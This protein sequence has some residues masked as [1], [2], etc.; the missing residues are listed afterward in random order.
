M[1]FKVAG[2]HGGK[3]YGLP[4]TGRRV[5]VPEIG[6]MRFTDGKWKDAFYF[7]DELGLMLQLDALHM[8][9]A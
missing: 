6:I 1:R 5:E 4:P 9:Q 8:L 7:A 2:T 3:L